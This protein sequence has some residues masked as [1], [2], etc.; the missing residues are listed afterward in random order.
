MLRLVYLKADRQLF[1][2]AKCHCLYCNATLPK[3]SMFVKGV[4]SPFRMNGWK[5]VKEKLHSVRSKNV[6]KL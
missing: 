2:V 1:F 5:V 4:K 3:F 6:R